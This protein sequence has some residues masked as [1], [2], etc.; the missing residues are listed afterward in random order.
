MDYVCAKDTKIR[1]KGGKGFVSRRGERRPTCCLRI[2]ICSFCFL[3]SSAAMI[4][5]RWSRCYIRVDRND[6]QSCAKR[7]YPYLKELQLLSVIYSGGLTE[8]E[9]YFTREGMRIRSQL[10]WVTHTNTRRD[11]LVIKMWNVVK[12][13]KIQHIK[14]IRAICGNMS[15]SKASY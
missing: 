15:G 6:L 10:R 8:T 2:L 1:R 11:I 7:L 3:L 13:K 5:T 14:C 9:M 4:A 12:E